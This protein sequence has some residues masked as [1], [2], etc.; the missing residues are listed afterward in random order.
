MEQAKIYLLIVKARSTN[1]MVQNYSIVRKNTPL[2]W[3]SVNK[4]EICSL[5]YSDIE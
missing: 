3:L 5:K 4:H 2:V 1:F